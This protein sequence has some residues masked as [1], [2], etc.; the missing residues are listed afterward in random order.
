MYMACKVV[1]WKLGMDAQAVISQ[2]AHGE[3]E[4]MIWNVRL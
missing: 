2:D 1:I 3:C 4:M